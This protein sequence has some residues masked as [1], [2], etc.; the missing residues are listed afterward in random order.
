MRKY[1]EFLGKLMSYWW[2]CV[3]V[4]HLHSAKKT[5]QLALEFLVIPKESS[6]DLVGTVERSKGVLK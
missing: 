2:C 4:W 6:P 3:L 1:A 5:A